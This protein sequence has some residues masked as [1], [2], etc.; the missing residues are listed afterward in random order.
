[1]KL[2][3]SHLPPWTVEVFY[4][5][6]EEDEARPLNQ[7]TL[8]CCTGHSVSVISGQSSAVF[9]NYRSCYVFPVAFAREN[10][11]YIYA[12]IFFSFLHTY[13]CFLVA[14]FCSSKFGVYEAKKEAQ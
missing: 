12:Y 9:S 6:H 3:F 11:P 14:T 1:M 10:K 4:A 2:T 5:V 7:P 13:C 8:V